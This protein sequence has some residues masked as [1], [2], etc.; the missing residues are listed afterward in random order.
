MTG[1]VV[2]P[3]RSPVARLRQLIHEIHRRS[4]WQVLGIY[5]VGSWIA[6]QVVDVLANNFGLPTWFPSFALA[7]L[8]IGGVAAVLLWGGVALGWFLFGRCYVGGLS[9]SPGAEYAL[10]RRPA[11]VHG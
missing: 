7:L 9:T 10:S 8:I 1:S 6:L 4:L 3:E 5:L 11:S 2:S